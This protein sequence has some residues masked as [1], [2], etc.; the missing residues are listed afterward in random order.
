MNPHVIEAAN[1]SRAWLK[2]IQYL[3]DCGGECF[4]LVAHI[5]RPTELDPPI[6][7]A[8]R[9]LISGHGL[10]TLKQVTY[11][12]F[13]RS[14][15][16]SSGRNGDKLFETYNRSNGVYE[17]LQRKYKR[18]F[19]WGSYFRRMTCYPA[20]GGPRNQ[21]KDIIDML[22]CRA[23]ICKGAYTISIQVPGVDG[24]R[25]RG[26]PCLNYIA[27]QLDS[28]RVLNMLA[29]YRSHDFI[30]RAY[31]NYLGLAHLMEFLCEQIDY[32]MGTLTC[33]SSRASIGN[34]GGR[35]S[36]PTISELRAFVGDLDC[37]E[38]V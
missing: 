34:L 31:G 16:L 21:L 17:R 3:L 19:G 18:R 30:E 15:Y 4:N 38:D 9:R 1:V 11:T 24:R 22:Q 2:A 29:V 13:P 37:H 27:L 14:L 6:H 12:I 33:L 20:S 28:P 35:A 32:S 7:S 25:T 36:W 26:G 8:Y 5:K 10:L 23:R